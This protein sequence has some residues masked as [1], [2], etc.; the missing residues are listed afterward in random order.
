MGLGAPDHLVSHRL[1]PS[2]GVLSLRGALV[3]TE[4]TTQLNLAGQLI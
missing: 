2:V 3:G 1:L 4:S